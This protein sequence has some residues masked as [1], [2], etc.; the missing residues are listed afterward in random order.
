M[1]GLTD[2]SLLWSREAPWP[3]VRVLCQPQVDAADEKNQR[4]AASHDVQ[5]FPTLKFFK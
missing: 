5:G 1:Q 2:Q 4:L 3:P